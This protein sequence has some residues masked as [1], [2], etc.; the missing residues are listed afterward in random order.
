M[1]DF[2]KFGL[3]VCKSRAAEF[4]NWATGEMKIKITVVKVEKSSG[5][6]VCTG[7]N[8]VNKLFAFE[9]QAAVTHEPFKAVFWP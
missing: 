5:K 2:P 1:C 6:N 4:Y 8:P 7:K 3:R 9:M